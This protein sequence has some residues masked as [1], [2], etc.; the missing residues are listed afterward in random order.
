MLNKFLFSYPIFLFL[1]GSLYHIFGMYKLF[2]DAF[3]L[4]LTWVHISMLA[5]NSFCIVG[6]I[7]RIKLCYLFSKYILL[8]FA[9]I[10]FGSL[11]YVLVNSESSIFPWINLVSFI[12]SL[13]AYI[14]LQNKQ[15]LFL[16]ISMQN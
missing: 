14:I 10:Q 16:K 13:F 1:I 5:I 9:L 2:F 4:W 11:I 12:F 8:L 6:L 15:P 7:K 3:S